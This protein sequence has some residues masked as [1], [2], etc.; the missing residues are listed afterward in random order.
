M[1]GVGVLVLLLLPFQMK[2]SRLLALFTLLSACQPSIEEQKAA[3]ET[4][5]AATIPPAATAVPAAQASA[6]STPALNDTLR[7]SNDLALRTS[8]GRKADFPKVPTK[9]RREITEADLIRQQA[10]GR[11][12]RKGQNLILTLANGKSVIFTNDT[13]TLR[14]DENEDTD[15]RYHYRGNLAD[16]PYWIVEETLYEAQHTFLI[17]QLTGVKTKVNGDLQLSPDH[18]RLLASYAGLVYEDDISTLQLFAIRQ[19]AA[20]L[21]WQ[22]N[23]KDWAPGR[24]HWL[25]DHTIAVEQLRLYNDSADVTHSSY[26]KLLLP[27]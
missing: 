11:V 10:N 15:K 17:N 13:F 22:K 20:F 16:L 26:I 12:R 1:A 18:T 8:P 4:V 9:S 24:T 3:S 23:L 21:L 6:A 27:H 14:G 2:R 25:D 5:A 19:Q 7:V